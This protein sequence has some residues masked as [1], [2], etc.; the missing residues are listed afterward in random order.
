MTANKNEAINLAKKID[1]LGETKIMNNGMKATITNY[2]K[3]NDID[4]QFEDGTIIRHTKYAYFQKGNI[5]NPN[6]KPHIGESRIMSCGQ[7][8]TIIAYRRGDDIDVRFENGIIVKHKQY[9]AFQRGK[10]AYPTVYLNKSKIM[11]NGLKA[12]VINYSSYKDIDVQFEDGIV[13]KNKTYQAFKADN[14]AHPNL[15]GNPKRISIFHNFEAKFIARTKDTA[16]YKCKCLSCNTEDIL[17]PQQ[18][19]QH[20]KAHEKEMLKETEEL[21]M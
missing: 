11:N 4:I 8:A 18:M 20:E 12:T 16:F 9:S 13:V 14:I 15:S 1:R 17:T 3:C 10:I 7:K 6:Y 5:V 19:I 21:E 2:S